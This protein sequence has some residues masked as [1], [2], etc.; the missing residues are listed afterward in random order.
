MSLINSIFTAVGL[1]EHYCLCPVFFSLRGQNCLIGNFS[2]STAKYLLNTCLRL[3]ISNNVT[4]Y[5]IFINLIQFN[6]ALWINNFIVISFHLIIYLIII[7]TVCFHNYQNISCPGPGS[8]SGD[9]KC[10]LAKRVSRI[11][12][13]M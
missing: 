1:K 11:V 8:G 2:Y 6:H 7:K 5:P 9:C 10:G 3:I 4:C 13:G 12:G